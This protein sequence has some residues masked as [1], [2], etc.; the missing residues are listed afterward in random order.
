MSEIAGGSENSPRDEQAG[1][2]SPILYCM[3]S[4]LKACPFAKT[5]ILNHT[6]MIACMPSED[7]YLLE[8]LPCLI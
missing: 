1:E 6:C 4:N 3:Y 2:N 8:Y 7:W 5:N